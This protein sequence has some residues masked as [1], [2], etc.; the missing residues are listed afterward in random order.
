[1]TSTS[2]PPP[3]WFF[4]QSAVIPWRRHHRGIEILLVTSA[5]KKRWIIPKGVIEPGMGARASARKE[6]LEEAGVDGIV[7]D[8]RIGEY[9]YRKW[10][11]NCRVQVFGMQVT[12]VHEHWD[13]EK[14]RKRRWVGLQQSQELVDTRDLKL[15]LR[16][17]ERMI[18]S[19]LD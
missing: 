13:E 3:S 5:R 18:N 14:V 10:N 11:G 12:D 19:L 17:F 8:E 6:A 9:F 4:E 7:S 2:S 16:R 15:L 1:M